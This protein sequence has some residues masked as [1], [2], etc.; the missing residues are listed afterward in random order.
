MLNDVASGG[1]LERASSLP[2]PAAGD[3][4]QPGVTIIELDVTA[5]PSVVG[6]EMPGAAKCLAKELAIFCPAIKVLIVESGYIRANTFSNIHHVEP[7]VAAD[8][9]PFNGAV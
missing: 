3:N 7:R 4:K 6:D 5:A 1:L 9:A 8:Y 2:L